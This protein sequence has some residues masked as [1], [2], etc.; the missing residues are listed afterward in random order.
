MVKHQ[1]AS[2]GRASRQARSAHCCSPTIDKVVTWVMAVHVVEY[3]DITVLIR[4]KVW[5]V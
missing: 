4:R 5:D 2:A 3:P 1:P